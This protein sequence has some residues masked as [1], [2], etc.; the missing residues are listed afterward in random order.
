[1][2]DVELLV[3]HNIGG[4]KHNEQWGRNKDDK[5]IRTI[6]HIPFVPANQW[7]DYHRQQ[8]TGTERNSENQSFVRVGQLNKRRPSQFEHQSIKRES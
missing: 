4:M 8:L 1:M 6:I 7:L 2:T 3:I 5:T